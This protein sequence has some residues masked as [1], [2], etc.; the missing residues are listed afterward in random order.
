[1]GK[2]RGNTALFFKIIPSLFTVGNLII[3]IISLL[4]SF[5]GYNAGAALLVI[6]GMVLDGLDGRVA[7]LLHAESNFGKELDSLSDVVT[8]GVADNV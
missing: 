2:L 4:L 3:G 8:F 5:Q 1:M 6:V 7:R